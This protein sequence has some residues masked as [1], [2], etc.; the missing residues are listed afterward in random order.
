MKYKK[1]SSIDMVNFKVVGYIGKCHQ[2]KT[3]FSL[4][5]EDDIQKDTPYFFLLIVF[6]P[7]I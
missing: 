5:N 2:A 3:F 1:I 4:K 6:Q 7:S